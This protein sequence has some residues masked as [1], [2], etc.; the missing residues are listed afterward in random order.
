MRNEQ[1]EI[2]G[3]RL[4]RRAIRGSAIAPLPD[5]NASRHYYP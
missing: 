4:R 5:G 1:C 2:G 3:L